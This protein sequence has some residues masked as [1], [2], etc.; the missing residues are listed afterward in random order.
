MLSSSQKCNK[1]CHFHL[2]FGI[3]AIL[4]IRAVIK[5][6][7]LMEPVLYN[8][9]GLRNTDSIFNQIINL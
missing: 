8:V 9:E 2:F 1:R 3:F 5:S 7:L 6:T 4:T